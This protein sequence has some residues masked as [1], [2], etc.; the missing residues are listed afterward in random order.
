[1]RHG[2]EDEQFYSDAT[3]TDP[4]P[5]P[6]FAALWATIQ[7]GIRPTAS[8]LVAEDNMVVGAHRA[9]LGAVSKGEVQHVV[10]LPHGRN[11]V[12]VW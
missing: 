8:G 11:M 9:Q 7:F 1:V 5:P 2:V 12:G 10:E 4:T 3:A 6:G